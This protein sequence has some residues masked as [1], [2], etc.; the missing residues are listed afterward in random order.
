MINFL[1]K[2]N[3][4]KTIIYLCLLVGVFFQLT[5]CRNAQ[6]VPPANLEYFKSKDSSFPASVNTQQPQTVVIQKGDILAIILNS[7]SAE[8]NEILNFTNV[9]TLPVSVFSGNAGGGAQPL[10]YS[11][12]SLGFVNIPVIGKMHLGGL[13]LKKA[14]EMIKAELEKS[15][16]SPVVNLRFMNHKFSVL[17]EA[18]KVG[19]FNLLDDHTTILDA[20][21]LA[22]D[23]TLYS[24]RDSITVIRTFENRREM[25]IVNLN[26]RSVFTS[27]YF[28]LKNDDIIYIAPTKNK[29][30]PEVPFK[31]TP[32]PSMFIQRL[33]IFISIVTFL[34]LIANYFK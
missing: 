1:M 17:G 7:F 32:P 29:V 34:T 33:P 16:K 5:S 30:V 6:R 24:K 3:K 12:D 13:T 26:D 14:E 25:G 28:Y 22:G 27:P 23:L 8:T 15:I 31:Q 18:N 2:T 11:V 9:N 4:L 10:G 19:I 20:L 21:A